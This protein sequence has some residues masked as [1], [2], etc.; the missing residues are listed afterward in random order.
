MVN[1]TVAL[2]VHAPCSGNLLLDI[3]ANAVTP[4]VHPPPWTWIFFAGINIFYAK[5]IYA[6]KRNLQILQIALVSEATP[7]ASEATTH[8]SEVSGWPPSS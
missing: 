3:F 2:R 6:K 7:H 1:N 5:Y 8:A 4:Q